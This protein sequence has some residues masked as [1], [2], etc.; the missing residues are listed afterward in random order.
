MVEAVVADLT[1]AVLALQGDVVGSAEWGCRFQRAAHGATIK[2]VHRGEFG[3]QP[4]GQGRSLALAQVGQAFVRI[5]LVPALQVD[6]A[7]TVS[8]H[9]KTH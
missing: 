7:L 2:D 9:E 5:A 6:Q 4:V 3:G 1:Q 8:Y